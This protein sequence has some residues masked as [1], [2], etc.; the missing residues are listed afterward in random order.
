M[1]L[2][3]RLGLAAALATV[4]VSLE[5]IAQEMPEISVVEQKQGVPVV[6]ISLI[7]LYNDYASIFSLPDR[8]ETYKRFSEVYLVSEHYN[9]ILAGLILCK[10]GKVADGKY[11]GRHANKQ[12][13]WVRNYVNGKKEGMQ[14]EWY[15]NGQLRVERNYVNGKCEGALTAWYDNGQLWLEENLTNN[16]LEG[17]QRVWSYNGQ[18]LLEETYFVNGRY[19]GIQRRWHENGRLASETYYFNGK[20]ESIHRDWHENGQLEF[21]MYYVNDKMVSQ[22]EWDKKGL[23]VYEWHLKKE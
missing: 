20:R 23:L 5:A 18:N 22:K 14:S 21:E 19:E 13:W 16:K 2:L 8:C 3:Q 6:K 17:M 11:I 4:P 15:D 9:G 10:D 1:G 7:S 12:L